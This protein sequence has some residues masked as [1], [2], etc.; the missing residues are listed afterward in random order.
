M[1]PET[2]AEMVAKLEEALTFAKGMREI[3]SITRALTMLERNDI[4]RTRLFIDAEAADA[5]ETPDEVAQRVVELA[6]EMDAL[7]D[8]LRGG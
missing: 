7:E 2:R 1:R 4:D 5:G 3:T 8:G 6:H